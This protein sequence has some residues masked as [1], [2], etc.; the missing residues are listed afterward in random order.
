MKRTSGTI[1]GMASILLANVVAAQAIDTNRPGFTFS[2]NTVAKGTWQLETGL[3]YTRNSSSSEATSLPAAEVR[4]GVAEQIEVFASGINWTENRNDGNKSS[5]FGDV[6][7]GTKLAISDP[8]AVTR[9]AFLFQL[10][11]PVGEDGFT[12]DRWDPTAA[13][14]WSSPAGLPISGTVKVSK[15]RSGYQ[16]DNG[17][18]ASFSLA[19][20]HHLFA[21]WEANVPEEGGNTHWLNGGYQFVLAEQMQLDA[22]LGLGLNDRTGDY[23]LGIGFSYRF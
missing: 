8:N 11:V 16:L 10:S 17:L 6:N 19:E 13:F 4:W 14:I 23:R 7:V 3:D 18:K 22:N 2:P 15:F 1:I 20:R 12:S 21:E 5:G 9:L